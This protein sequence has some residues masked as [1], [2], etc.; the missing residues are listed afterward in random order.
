MK[1]DRSKKNGLGEKLKKVII[2]GDFLRDLDERA[3]KRG[4]YSYNEL[5]IDDNSPLSYLN[6]ARNERAMIAIDILTEATQA[7]G[8]TPKS[9]I[10]GRRRKAY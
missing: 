2:A 8:I 5:L 1:C 6:P 10:F 7:L 4:F 9:K 3:Q